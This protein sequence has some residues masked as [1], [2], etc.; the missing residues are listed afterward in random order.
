MTAREEQ[1][2]AGDV[3]P[4]YM[5]VEQFAAHRQVGRTTVFHWLS[6]GLPSAKQGR[7]RRIRC[8]VADKWLDEGHANR[9][10]AKPRSLPRSA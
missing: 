6:L 5:T 7:T 4:L 9:P 2:G 10:A 1:S 3:R 8:E